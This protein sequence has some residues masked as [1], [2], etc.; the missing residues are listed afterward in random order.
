[1]QNLQLRAAGK[2]IDAGLPNI[3]G[4]FDC[5]SISYQNLTSIWGDNNLFKQSK[6]AGNTSNE[7]ANQ[8]NSNDDY[9]PMWRVKFDAKAC[10]D[11]YGNSITVQ[12]AA[13]T[14]KF[15]LKY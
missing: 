8:V 10:N 14:I 13:C 3:T 9:V 6:L 1:M 15:L 4:H 12:P 11:L 5:R 7:K 2:Y